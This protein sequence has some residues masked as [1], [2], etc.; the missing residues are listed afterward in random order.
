MSETTGAVEP[1]KDRFRHL[2][3]PIRLSEMSEG[4]QVSRPAPFDGD[5]NVDQDNALRAGG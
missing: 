1:S 2:P 5:R 4:Q 3:E